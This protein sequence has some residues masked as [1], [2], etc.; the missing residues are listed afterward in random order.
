MNQIGIKICGVTTLD[1]AR[2]A[3][4]AGATMLGLNFYRPS[5]RC[6]SLATAREIRNSLPGN[7]VAVGVYADASAEFVRSSAQQVGLAAVQLHGDISIAECR[8]LARDFRVIRAVPTGANE[9]QRWTAFDLLVDAHHPELRGGTGLICDWNAAAEIRGFA[10]Y[11]ML[12][13]GLNAGNIADAL[14]AVN[15]DAV[16]VCSGIES[17]P[18]RKDHDAT[19]AFV[20]AVRAAQPTPAWR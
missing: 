20:A 19:R 18:G 9:A 4:N 16:D 3:V 2:A 11:L 6:I 5:P 1:D 10:K 7:V 12:S 17:S 8:E 13:G 14:A 15:P